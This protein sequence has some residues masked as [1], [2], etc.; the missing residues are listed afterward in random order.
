MGWPTPGTAG[1]NLHYRR[2]NR[3]NRIVAN[4]ITTHETLLAR[5]SDEPD[6]SAW[7]DFCERYGELIRRFALRQ[8]LQPADCDDVLQDVLMALTQ[9]LPGFRYDPQIGRFRSY[10]KTIVLRAV[11]KRFRQKR[12]EGPVVDIEQAVTRLA[13]DADTQRLWDEEWQQHHFRL[14]MG[15]IR[16]E[17][18]A[19]DVQAFE[20][21]VGQQLA[22]ADTARQLGISVD[23]V[24]QAKSR[25]M[26]RLGRLIEQQTAE[27]G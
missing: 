9:S 12:G 14:A 20:A 17:F 6:P 26:K 22:A 5:L 27:E 4:P 10:L 21:Y 8:N 16:V 15:T 24:Y 23:Q 13:T 18:N 19:T 2:Q 11:F 1:P 25:I 7:R 3:Y